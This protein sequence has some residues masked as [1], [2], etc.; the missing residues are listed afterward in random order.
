MGWPL[1]ASFAWTLVIMAEIDAAP[2]GR[3]LSRRTFAPV[4]GWV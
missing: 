2:E 3:K 4:T 1:A